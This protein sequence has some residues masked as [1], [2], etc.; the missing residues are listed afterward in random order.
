MSSEARI[1]RLI[2]GM[3]ADRQFTGQYLAKESLVPEIG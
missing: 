1:H 3:T 2:G